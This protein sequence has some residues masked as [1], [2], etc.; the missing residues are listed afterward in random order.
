[1]RNCTT[2]KDAYLKIKKKYRVHHQAKSNFDLR[3]VPSLK[4][5]SENSKFILTKKIPKTS[6]ISMLSPYF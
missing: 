5:S 2:C 3:T 4:K 1:M 6:H